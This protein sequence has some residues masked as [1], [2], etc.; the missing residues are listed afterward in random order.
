MVLISLRPQVAVCVQ[1]GIL[2]VLGRDWMDAL[3]PHPYCLI[4]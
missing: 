4:G 1:V 2:G 3:G